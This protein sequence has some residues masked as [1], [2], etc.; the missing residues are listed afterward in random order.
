MKEK[1][2]GL[3]IG[4]PAIGAGLAGGD[5]GIILYIIDEE[6]KDANH[7]FVEFVK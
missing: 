5:W 7:T 6:L 3:R 1:F 2:S 4:Y